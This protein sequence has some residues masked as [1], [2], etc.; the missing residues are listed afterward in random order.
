MR[1]LEDVVHRFTA[2]RPPVVLLGGLPIVRALGAAR[3]P[4]VVASPL[5]RTPG[6]VSRYASAALRLPPLAKSREAAET[7]VRAGERL[8]ARLGHPV[9][10]FYSNDDHLELLEAH[11]AVLSASFAMILNDPDV[12][13]A[14]VHKDRFQVFARARGLPVPRRF[15]W[16]E[17]AR[18]DA[19]VLAKPRAKI[20]WQH[21]AV[22]LRL[23]GGEGKARV[24]ASGREVLANR[25][26]CRLREQLMF[27][28]YVRGDDRN[29]WSFHGFADEKG[30]PLAWFVGRKIRTYP[31][32]T[33]V[34]TYLELA[35]NDDVAA[36]GREIV[37]RAGLKGIFKIDLKQDS[38]SGALRV[39]EIN[40][41]F[42]LWHC[43]GAPNGVNLP[44]VA[45]DYLVYRR[46]PQAAGY[47]TTYRWL[48]PRN[49]YRTFRE[50]AARGELSSWAWLRSLAYWPKVYDVFSW[51]DPVPYLDVLQERLKG[52]VRL[53]G[54]VWR[55]LFSA[56]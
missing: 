43:L 14:M 46:R 4:V 30:E 48:S 15:E 20:D 44:Q 37:A 25:L 19:P 11:R 10:L 41:R 6:M 33:G 12:A 29:I 7:L 35:H 56:S 55:R 54:R 53:P 39:L 32:L 23:F 18:L 31:A 22:H 27:Q 9:P 26:A 51:T 13:W 42:N 28:E 38:A 34:S 1:P 8:R 2:Q 50:L 40:P 52:L 24:F 16:D 5:Q 3:I 36:L 21:S 45:Y 17:L 49:D 47:R